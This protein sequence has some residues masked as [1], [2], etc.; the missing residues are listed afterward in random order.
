[1]SPRGWVAV[2]ATPPPGGALTPCCGVAPRDLPRFHGVTPDLTKVTCRARRTAPLREL[3]AM[4]LSQ[5]KATG[6]AEGPRLPHD[7]DG[8]TWDPRCAVCVGDVNALA[9]AVAQALAEVIAE[10]TGQANTLAGTPTPRPP[11]RQ[12]ADPE[13]TP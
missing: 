7:R 5:V 9:G 1:M 10:S 13:G 6:M 2:H 8:H 11:R 12:P 3:A 4:V